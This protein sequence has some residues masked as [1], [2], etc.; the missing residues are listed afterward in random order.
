MAFTTHDH[1]GNDT[2]GNSVLRVLTAFFDWLVS[3]SER[4]PAMRRASA[5]QAMTDAELEQIGITREQIPSVAMRG[6]AAL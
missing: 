6:Y 5:L 4:H 1:S 2:Q 3:I